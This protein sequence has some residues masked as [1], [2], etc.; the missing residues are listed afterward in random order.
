MG[1]SPWPTPLAGTSPARAQAGR[2]NVECLP[3]VATRAK[4]GL[5]P[6]YMLIHDGSTILYGKH[7]SQ[8]VVNSTHAL[9]VQ[10]F[11]LVDKETL[12]DCDHLRDVDDGRLAQ[13]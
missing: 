1:L 2:L 12:V 4:A 8:T 3:A 13:A 5:R 7:E 11:D 6:L 10:R 9:F